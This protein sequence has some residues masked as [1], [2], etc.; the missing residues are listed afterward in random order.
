MRQDTTTQ[1]IMAIPDMASDVRPKPQR[2]QSSERP[3][4]EIISPRR[5]A[6][7]G[8]AFIRNALKLRG[9]W[10]RVSK[11]LIFEVRRYPIKNYNGR[12]STPG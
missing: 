3:H 9:P 10:A 12:R 6:W 1:E 11:T 2:M 8:G 4:T 7:L 5:K